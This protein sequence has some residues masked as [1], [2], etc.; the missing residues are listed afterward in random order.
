MENKLLLLK[1][2]VINSQNSV[3]D[4]KESDLKS[5]KANLKLRISELQETFK[6]K[7]NIQK[8]YDD[9]QF[10]LEYA[11]LNLSSLISAKEEYQLSLAQTTIPWKIINPTNVES[12]P[13]KPSIPFNLA[14]S[15]IFALF[16]SALIV[17]LRERFDYVFHNIEELEDEISIPIFGQIPYLSTFEGLRDNK[18]YVLDLLDN[19]TSS[20]NSGISN[21]ELINKNYERFSYQEAYRNLYTSL[22]F[23]S[24][25]EKSNLIAI[26]SSLPAEGKSIFIIILAKTLAELGKNVLLIDLDLRKPQLHHRLGINNLRGFSD[27]FYNTKLSW[28]DLKQ[29]VK[30]YPSWDV[31]TSGKEPPNPVTNLSSDKFNQIINDIKNAGKYEYILFDTPPSLGFPDAT[32]I[33]RNTDLLLLIVGLN[34]VSKD[35]PLKVIKKINSSG[36]DISGIVSNSLKFSKI[37]NKE[38]IDYYS[39]YVKDNNFEDNKEMQIESSNNKIDFLKKVFIQNINKFFEWVDK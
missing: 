14:T 31:I 15:V 18:K 6:F 26:T 22:R 3:I 25:E 11:R 23:L 36:L 13:Y 8:E 30:G 35:I 12:T 2:K 32:L 34:F 28:K 7:P 16:T 24:N 1:P 39:D 37:S 19:S 5:K 4:R 38:N 21:E 9:I 29:T 20:L 10:K 27:L 33:S 17:F